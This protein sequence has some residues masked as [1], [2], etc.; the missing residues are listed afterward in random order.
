M[1]MWQNFVRY[2]GFV[3]LVAVTCLG[4]V[5]C[6]PGLAADTVDVAAT[7]VDSET[8]EPLEGAAFGGRAYTN[9]VETASDPAL[10]SDDTVSHRRL[11]RADGTFELQFLDFGAY[12][13]NP[14]LRANLPTPDR[15]EFIIVRDGVPE[16]RT[17]GPND[18]YETLYL[19]GGCEQVVSV[20]IT[21]D[22]VSEDEDGN[23]VITLTEP[24]HVPSCN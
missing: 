4:F 18:E 23:R 24:I 2:A 6:I 3:S 12:S 19:T 8:L 9:G 13:I 22:M 15:I 1:C 21:S 5:G 11:S 10:L 14:A 20:D 17:S 7:L 16:Y